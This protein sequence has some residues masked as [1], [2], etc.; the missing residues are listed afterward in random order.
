MTRSVAGSIVAGCY[1]S[2]FF[3]DEPLCDQFTPKRLPVP[4]CP[5]RSSR[6]TT[7]FINVSKQQIRGID[8]AAQWTQ[9]LGSLGALTVNTQWTRN[10]EDTVALFDNT[11]ED[12]SGRAGHPETVGNLYLTLDKEAWSFYWGIDYIG[13]TDN[14][15]SF[16][17]DTV[18]E[19][20]RRSGWH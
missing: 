17:F 19:C 2:P 20:A 14:S 12:L 8:V 7:P 18:N 15:E 11:E 9:E 1:E 6:S 3:P 13:S 4:H 16:G 5:M 10:L